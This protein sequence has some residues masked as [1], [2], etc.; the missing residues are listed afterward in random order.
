MNSNGRFAGVN[1]FRFLEF[2]DY[3][4]SS[5]GFKS[6]SKRNILEI[7]NNVVYDLMDRVESMKVIVKMKHLLLDVINWILS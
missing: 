7:Y 4:L 1:S 3:Y 6:K 2:A 5:I